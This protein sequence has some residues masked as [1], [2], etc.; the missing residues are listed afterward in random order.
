MV[1]IIFWI[2]VHPIDPRVTKEV[3]SCLSVKISCIY[4]LLSVENIQANIAPLIKARVAF[5]SLFD[6]FVS[7]L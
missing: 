3:G 4:I 6:F 2:H 1:R 7:R 5:S